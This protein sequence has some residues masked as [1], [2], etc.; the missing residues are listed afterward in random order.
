MRLARHVALLVVETLR[1]GAT[2]R[3]YGVA[4]VVVV[5]LVLLALALTAQVAA[6]VVLYPFA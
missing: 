6:P 1:F 3:R 4:L 5:G 2:T